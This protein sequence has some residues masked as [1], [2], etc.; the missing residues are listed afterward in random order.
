MAAVSIKNST[1][2]KDANL[3]SYWQLNGNYTDSKGSYNLTAGASVA[4]DVTGKFLGA[5]DF[6]A[7]NSQYASNTSANNLDIATNQ[8][9]MAWIK[10]ESFIS[11]SAIMGLSGSTDDTNRKLIYEPDTS[12]VLSFYFQNMGG[13]FNTSNALNVGEWNFVAC[14]I[15]TAKYIKVYINGTKTQGQGTGTIP[16]GSNS[17]SI[18]RM[19]SYNGRYFDGIIDD[20]AFFSRVLSDQEVDDHYTGADALPSSNFFAFM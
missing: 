4:A 16:T 12:G 15:T 5:K 13:G 20:V 6:E 11:G 18:G 19:G 9:W 10:P 3:V 17:F 14:S 8:T 7:S 1:L 2:Y